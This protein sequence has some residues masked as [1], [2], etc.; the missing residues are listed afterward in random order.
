[1]LD[2]S[3]YD[4][5]YTVVDIETTGMS[6]EKGARIVE[7]AAVRI[8][9]G[10]RLK[11]ED[12]FYSLIN[13]EVTIPYSAFRIH[14]IS[15]ELTKNAPT[16]EPVLKAFIEYA[17]DTVIVG[18]NISFDYSFLSYYANYYGLNFHN[19]Y[20]IDTIKVV[21]KIAP[22]LKRYNLD[23]LINY[24]GLW[25]IVDVGYRHRADYDVMATALIFIRAITIMEHHNDNI[26]L[27]DLL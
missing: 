17:K 14:K 23:S 15:N 25:E 24:F 9:E 13:P 21:K 12:T 16:L 8:G 26:K 2:K 1:M 5:T 20:I 3:I 4:L 19:Y 6:P 22:K 7:I 11:K 18:Q 10:L 27:I